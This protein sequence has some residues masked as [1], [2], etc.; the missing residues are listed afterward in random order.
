MCV[1]QISPNA[2][3]HVL[4]FGLESNIPSLFFGVGIDCCTF[5]DLG[6]NPM[7]ALL[8]AVELEI[9]SWTIFYAP[10]HLIFVLA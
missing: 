5:G 2:F 7:F 6:S 4:K 3:V 9:P 1:I 8:L 10:T